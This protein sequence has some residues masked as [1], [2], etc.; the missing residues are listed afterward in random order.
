MK[1]WRTAGAPDSALEG[2]QLIL[3]SELTRRRRKL[4]HATSQ[5]RDELL[6]LE[7]L[8]H[9]PAFHEQVGTYDGK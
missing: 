4:D 9:P 7:L 3:A 1:L 8:P 6:Y 2:L 5:V